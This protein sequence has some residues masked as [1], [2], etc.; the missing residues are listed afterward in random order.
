MARIADSTQDELGKAR[1][2]RDAHENEREYRAALI[3]LLTA[4]RGF[5]AEEAADTFGTDV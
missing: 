3:V 5:T 2:L 1:E 4:E